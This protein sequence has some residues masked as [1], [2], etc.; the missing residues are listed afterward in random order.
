MRI[1]VDLGG[2]K[3]E[4][5]A[6]DGG[7]AELVRTRVATPGGDYEKT[8]AAIVS[9]VRDIEE[10]LGQRGSI[11]IGT[12]GATSPVTGLLKNA[13]STVLIGKDFKN[14]ISAALNRDVRVANDANCFALSESVDG[15]AC[16]A[17]VVFGVILGTGVGGGISVDGRILSGANRV[18]GEWGHMPLPW[19]RED[20]RPGPECYCGKRGCIETWLAG[21]RL[22][23]HYQSRG[24]NAVPATQIARAALDGDAVAARVLEDYEDRLA[25]GLSVVIDILDPDAIVLGGGLSN[26]PGLCARVKPRLVQ[27]VLAGEVQTRLVC[28]AHGDSSGVRGA[29]MLWPRDRP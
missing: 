14:D 8:L 11:G 26:I 18:A 7:G 19:P 22:S 16:G 1:G 12:P 25:R 17:G 2:T 27:Y 29:A 6:I 21:P 23:A 9:L 3:I 15:A 5:I 28:A 20:E 13:N 10:K 24:G 4:I